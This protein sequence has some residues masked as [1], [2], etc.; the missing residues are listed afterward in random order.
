MNKNNAGLEAGKLA[1]TFLVNLG[2]K[3]VAQNHHC[4]YIVKLI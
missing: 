1:A 4:K 3:L 2:L